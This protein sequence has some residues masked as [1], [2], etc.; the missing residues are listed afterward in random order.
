MAITLNLYYTGQNGSALRFAEEMVSS[1]TVKLIREEAGNL[2]YDYFV[3]LDNPETVL[4]IDSWISQEA[5]DAHHSS[6]MMKK[7]AELR[8]KYDLHMRAERFVSDENGVSKRDA[9]FLRV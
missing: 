3:P 4:L 1:G 6:P 9:E 8:R 7:I 5:L 2:R